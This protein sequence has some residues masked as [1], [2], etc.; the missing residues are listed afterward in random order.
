MITFNISKVNRKLIQIQLNTTRVHHMYCY[1]YLFLGQHA[2]RNKKREE[3][4]HKLKLQQFYLILA[5][6]FCLCYFDWPVSNAGGKHVRASDSWWGRSRRVRGEAE[7]AKRLWKCS[8]RRATSKHWDSPKTSNRSVTDR[9]KVIQMLLNCVL[10]Y[11]SFT[12]L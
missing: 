11:V 1:K 6:C 8:Y 9:D 7:G 2:V 12:C 3:V 4:P 10:S 5:H